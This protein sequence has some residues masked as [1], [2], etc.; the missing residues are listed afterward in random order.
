MICAASLSTSAASRRLPAVAISV[1]V[2][3]LVYWAAE[4]YS[5]ALARR[6]AKKTNLT[7]SDYREILEQGWP[8][9]SASYVPLAT[10]LVAWALGASVTV[11]VNLALGVA[12]GLLVAAGFLASRA[13]GITGGRLLASTAVT[14]V[15][16]LAMV[17]LKNLLH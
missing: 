15:F 13:S 10:L 6:L 8:L 14:G 17:A 5:H 4:S 3:V 12:T 7:R 16:G 9:V 11:A 2:T 1:L